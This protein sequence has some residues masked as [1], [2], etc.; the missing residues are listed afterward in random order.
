M[1]GFEIQPFSDDLRDWAR[2]L[3][4]EHWGSVEVVAKG[5][6]HRADELPGFVALVDS[7]PVGLLTYRIE[8]NGCE[9]VTLNSLRE[10]QG[11]GSALVKAVQEAA[12]SAGVNRLWLIT[13]NDNL[14]ALRFYQ[15]MG[16]VVAA[17][18]VG[19]VE[20]SRRLKPSIPLIGKHGIPIRDEIE[21]Q[22]LT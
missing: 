9:I 4:T 12:L 6:P 2:E 18:H 7:H 14:E 10:R 22:L 20:N 21:L 5:R 1:A 3:L 8:A 17:C 16:F 19:A 11:I 13:T 15:K